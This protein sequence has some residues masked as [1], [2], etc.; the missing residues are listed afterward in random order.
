MGRTGQ[1]KMF[2]VCRSMP[3]RQGIV[4]LLE[5]VESKRKC[6]GPPDRQHSVSR[7]F[8]QLEEGLRAQICRVA[9]APNT[10]PT[11]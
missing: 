1:G 3:S 8:T 10:V 7:D 9:G 6:L 5:Q 11:R 4:R 2:G